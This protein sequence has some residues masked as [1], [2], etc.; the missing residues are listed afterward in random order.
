MSTACTR[1]QPE[2]RCCPSGRGGFPRRRQAD[3][4]HTSPSAQPLPRCRAQWG[5]GGPASGVNMPRPMAG[6]WWAAQRCSDNSR[7]YRSVALP[8][9]VCVAYDSG[10]TMQARRPRHGYSPAVL[11]HGCV[12]G[13]RCLGDGLHER[14]GRSM[15]E[16]FDFH[17]LTIEVTS[18]SA[19]LLE[20][21]RRDFAFFRVPAHQTAGAGGGAP[22]PSSL[23][24]APGHPGHCLHSPQ[25]LLP[26]PEHHLHRLLWQRIGRLRQAKEA[27]SAVWNGCRSG[28]R[29]HLICSFYRSWESTWTA[30]ESTGYTP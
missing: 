5:S 3:R 12:C 2:N 21:V 29:D 19:A 16:C 26:E 14:E 20:V 1:G 24:R 18:P 23:G 22:G 11:A 10:W 9:S 28:A 6:P 27:V 13:A 4:G 8:T 17:G 25:R 7:L 30:G 15:A